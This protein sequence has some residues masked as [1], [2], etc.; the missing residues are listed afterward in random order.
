MKVA[1]LGPHGTFSEEAAHR[2]FKDRHIDW[3]MCDSV[4]EV[5]EAVGDG[6]ADWG[7]APIENAIEGTI[8]MTV[9]SLLV[10]DLYIAG[11]VIL[12]VSLHLLGT[13]GTKEEDIQEVWS[14]PPAL[15]QCREYIRSLKVKT[16]HFDS[17]ASAAEA[18]REAGRNDVAA[19]AS[20]YAGD[21]FGLVKVRRNIEESYENQTR[22]VVVT[23]DKKAPADAK[24][25]MLQVIPSDEYTGVLSSILNVF[26][27]L[28]INLTWIESRP[29]KKKLG[30]YQFFLEAGFGVQDPLIEKAVAVLQTYGH[31]V[32]ILGS[33]TA[34]KLD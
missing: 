29:T 24:K 10:N 15:A 13:P 17:T 33:F 34:T 20:A 3:H 27:A 5:L 23:K 19:V 18:I 30:A 12:P 4:P 11:E 28:N 31:E 6:L 26:S 2:Y 9:D 21:L 32:N 1:Y 25:T 14:I 22:F 7:I 16:R 8:N